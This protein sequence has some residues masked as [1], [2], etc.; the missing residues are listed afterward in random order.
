MFSITN[1]HGLFAWNLGKNYFYNSTHGYSLFCLII[2]I[3]V[4]N[5][6]VYEFHQSQQTFL[7]VKH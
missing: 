1:L 6:G 3:A 2:N 7:F 5:R 4:V